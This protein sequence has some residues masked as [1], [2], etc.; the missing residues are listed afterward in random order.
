MLSIGT[1]THKNVLKGTCM[2]IM[3]PEEG[4]FTK[5]IYIFLK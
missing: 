2:E 5:D 4:C 3:F 1:D